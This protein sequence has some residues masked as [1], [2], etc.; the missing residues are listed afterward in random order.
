MSKKIQTGCGIAGAV[1]MAL[2]FIMK[3]V[4]SVLEF[5][6]A[7]RYNYSTYYMY[8][9][10]SLFVF[11]VAVLAFAF[12]IVS[13]TR[14][15]DKAIVAEIMIAVCFVTGFYY[16]DLAYAI[17]AAVFIAIAAILYSIYFA[18]VV[19]AD[20]SQAEAVQPKSEATFEQKADRLV[21]YKRM[22]DDGLLSEEEFAAIKKSVLGE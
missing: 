11:V 12:A 16:M 13:L 6:N 3:F 19:T 15:G 2:G 9:T 8:A 7:D 5:I 22:L 21:S 10:L 18:S 4:C 20:K 1:F 17:C 14:K